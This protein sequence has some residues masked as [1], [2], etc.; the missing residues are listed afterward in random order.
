MDNVFRSDN[1][2]ITEDECK[3]EGEDEAHGAAAGVNMI[4]VV[5]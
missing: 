2:E 1:T 3:E 5:K 4:G